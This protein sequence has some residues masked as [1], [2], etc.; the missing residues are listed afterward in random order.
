M[1][2]RSTRSKNPV[3]PSKQKK[4]ATKPTPDSESDDDQYGEE[5]EETKSLDSDALD[6][7]E[8]LPKTRTKRKRVASPAKKKLSP[9]EKKMR[10]AGHSDGELDDLDFELAEGQEVVGV[11]VEAPKDGRGEF[12]SLKF[13]DNGIERH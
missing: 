6:E 2:T 12:S 8:E 4:R 9:S 3:S 1:A 10:K 11:I 5:E 13:I 7:D